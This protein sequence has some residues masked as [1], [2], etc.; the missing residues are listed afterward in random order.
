MASYKDLSW[1]KTSMNCHTFQWGKRQKG[2][3]VVFI[4]INYVI[5]TIILLVS[6]FNK[7]NNAVR[8]ILQREELEKSMPV[9]LTKDICAMINLIKGYFLLK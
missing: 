7:Y 4:I 9:Q 8:F 3:C 1:D 2:N 5:F 6:P